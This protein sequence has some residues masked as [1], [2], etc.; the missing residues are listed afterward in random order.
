[1][2]AKKKPAR[3]RPAALV[4]VMAPDYV[5][6][7]SVPYEVRIVDLAEASYGT[8]TELADSKVIRYRLTFASPIDL[9]LTIAHEAL[10]AACAENMVNI[11]DHKELDRAAHIVAEHFLA[12]VMAQ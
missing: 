2:T 9:L 12:W 5:T 3:E 1:M 10:E 7:C 8:T 6:T 11:E 4:T